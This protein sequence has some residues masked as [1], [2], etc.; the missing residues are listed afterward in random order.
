MI[1]LTELRALVDWDPQKDGELDDVL[2]EVI[3]DWEMLTGRP[4]QKQT[5]R[6]DEIRVEHHLDTLLWLPLTPVL[7]ITTVEE[8]SAG[9]GDYSTLTASSYHLTAS[10]GRLER[11]AGA[12]KP[13]VRVTYDGGY[14]ATTCPSQIKRA[15][16]LQ[17]RFLAARLASPNLIVKGKSVGGRAGGGGEATF[18][19]RADFHPRFIKLAQNH[20][21]RV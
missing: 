5:G 3:S 18:F 7:A 9:S 2:A 12:W 17:A 21:R 11:L 20:R 13:N 14:D 4:W 15:L 8:R 19:E 10:S 6:V 1:T 16:A